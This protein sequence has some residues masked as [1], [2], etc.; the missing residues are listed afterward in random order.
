MGTTSSVLVAA[1][2]APVAALEICPAASS[3]A[4]EQ[5]ALEIAT[6]PR[7]THPSA[8]VVWRREAPRWVLYL[9]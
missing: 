3:G 9:F 1:L 2:D 8:A 5:A 4:L 7:R 6:L